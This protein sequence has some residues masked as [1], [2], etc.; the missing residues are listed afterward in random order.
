MNKLTKIGVSAL[1]GSL[2]SV[3]GA[4]AGEL[5]VAGGATATYSSN[6]GSV[7]GNPIGMS[8]GITFTGSGELDNGTTFT[9]T[10][11]NTDQSAYSASSIALVTPSMGT[12]TIDQGAGGSGIDRYDDKMPTAWEETTGTSLGTGLQTVAGVAGHANIDWNISPD[13]L[14]DGFTA[15]LAFTPKAGGLGANDKASTGS[16][17]EAM[18]AGYDIALSY[19]GYEGINIFGGYSNI[20]QAADDFLADRTSYVLGAT[21]AVGMV[22]VGY[23]WSRDNLND[24]NDGTSFY[25]NDAFGINFAINDDLSIS[26]GQHKSKRGLMSGANS[27]TN[28]AES[29]QLAYTMGGASIKIAESSV[30]NASYVSTTTHDR[31]GTTI[32]LS[33]AF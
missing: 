5:S 20:E 17:N 11:T 8:S 13:M 14:P 9:L 1:C 27:V 28:T 12:F 29:L 30:D 7:T 21:Y 33:L 25:E 24:R 15:A 32:A 3:A 18:G 23:Q 19:S 2:A 6:E 16:S 31:D 26:Y 4:H 22:T 10:I